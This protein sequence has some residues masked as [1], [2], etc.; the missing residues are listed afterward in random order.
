MKTWLKRIGV[1]FGVTLVAMVLAFTIIGPALQHVPA[2]QKSVLY[3]GM[4]GQA[5][6]VTPDYQLD[7]TADDVQ[8]QAALN[9]LPAT[10]GRLVVYGG[11]WDLNAT[12]SRAINNVTIQGA[13]K[14]TYFTND[15]ATAIFSAGAQTGW[16]FEDFRTDAGY[17]TVSSALDTIV[18]NVYNNAALVGRTVR[19]ATY[20]VAASD[21]SATE[22][23]QADWTC[24][25]TNDE[26]ELQAANK[27]ANGMEV[28]LT[29]H[30]FNIQTTDL[31]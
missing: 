24:D 29:G 10:G 8:L 20:V 31:T 3:L 21:A 23:T 11:N 14:G 5:Y 22:K 9:A 12:V 7:G 2:I 1:Q 26:S 25:G 16:V 15:G 6:A 17:L 13:G 4:A 30:T 27:A 28:R 19:A 18:S